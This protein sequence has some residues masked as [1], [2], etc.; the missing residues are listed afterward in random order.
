MLRY[1]GTLGKHEDD[2]YLEMKPPLHSG[3]QIDHC[4]HVLSAASTLD[5]LFEGAKE[6]SWYG[7][8]EFGVS[9]TRPWICAL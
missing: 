4:T 6:W 7:N 5:T 9:G 8:E 2:G 1:H 3:Y